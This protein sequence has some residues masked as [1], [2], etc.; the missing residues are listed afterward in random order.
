MNKKTDLVIFAPLLLAVI[1]LL[2]TVFVS[3]NKAIFGN[4]T[5]VYADTAA[6]P[7]ASPTVTYRGSTSAN[8][9]FSGTGLA[10]TLP[11][12]IQ[13]GD[14]L[15]AVAGTNGAKSSWSTPTG[16]TQGANTNSTD[17]QG[18]TWWWKVADGSEA[19]SR[20]AFR[21][22]KYADGGV[23]VNVYAGANANPIAGV[24]NF[25][26]T[27]NYGNGFVNA[28]NVAGVSLNTSVTAVPLIFVSWQPDASTVTWP[29]GFA[30]ES[31]ASDG[32]STVAVA[33]SLSSMTSDTFPGY[34]LPIS[35]VEAVVQTLQVLIKVQ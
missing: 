26:T 35:P 12:N 18:I 28:A 7:S 2:A 33:E 15:I 31:T 11:T 5:K 21:S 8:G 4:S 13:T 34:T 32:F 19:G 22:S 1:F 20:V 25:T 10:I 17:T 27:D 23:V 3:D 14:L 16:W 9:V 29:A 24:S 30:F 6:T